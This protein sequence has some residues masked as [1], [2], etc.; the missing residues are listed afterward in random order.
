MAV[1]VGLRGS[2]GAQGAFLVARQVGQAVDALLA[3]AADAKPLVSR[4]H[5]PRSA[6]RARKT[7]APSLDIPSSDTLPDAGM[8]ACA[9]QF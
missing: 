1:A 8:R 7:C 3:L 2:Q 4:H 5:T 9:R 6:A